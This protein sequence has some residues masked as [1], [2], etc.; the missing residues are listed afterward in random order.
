MRIVMTVSL[1][2][3]GAAIYTP[4]LAAIAQSLAQNGNALAQV[5]PAAAG[6]G[7]ILSGGA[8][9]R[10][11]Q[12]GQYRA[13]ILSGG[14]LF[15]IGSLCSWQLFFSFYG[16]LAGALLLGVGIGLVCPAAVGLIT[17]SFY[18]EEKQRAMGLQSVAAY[19]GAML[20]LVTGGYLSAHC[21]WRMVFL[22]GLLIVP[23]LLL[24]WVTPIA[25][26]QSMESIR[27]DILPEQEQEKENRNRHRLPGILGI[28]FLISG[29]AGITTSNLS[30]LIAEKALGDSPQVSAAGFFVLAG[31][32]IAAAAYGRGQALL[33]KYLLAF[34]FGLLA[35]GQALCGWGISLPVI[36]IGS[37]LAGGALGIAIPYLFLAAAD[38]G[39][40][41]G[42]SNA[43]AVMIASNLGAVLPPL[44]T[45]GLSV[46]G[47]STVSWRYAV[48]AVLAGGM[49]AAL[50]LLAWRE[51][52]E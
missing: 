48:S 49:M 7:V 35:I 1:V 38:C 26:K 8:A 6:I 29:L 46:I 15:A 24:T 13:A 45:F 17:A 52:E 30:M 27:T 20:L 16:L 51:K 9:E 34:G 40:S 10:F 4:V 31:A 50:G 33:K 18:G 14:T 47:T 2:Q 39:K 43:G 41:A 11:C 44:V 12:K 25:A 42:R 21:P 5:L 37:F 23:G 32:A 3:M 22:A 28:V 36:A 19:G